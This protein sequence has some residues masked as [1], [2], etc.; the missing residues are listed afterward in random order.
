[1]RRVR[2]L[3]VVL[4]D[5]VVIVEDDELSSCMPFRSVATKELRSA[6]RWRLIDDVHLVISY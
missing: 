2:L 1:M 4:V 6:A 3:H 5:V